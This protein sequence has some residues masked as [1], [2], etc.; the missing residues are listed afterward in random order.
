MVSEVFSDFNDSMISAQFVMQT[1]A[2]GQSLNRVYVMEPSAELLCESQVWGH[3]VNFSQSVLTAGSCP[4]E[5]APQI[6]LVSVAY[7][8]A[9]AAISPCTGWSREIFL[10][11]LTALIFVLS[12]VNVLSFPEVNITHSG[13]IVSVLFLLSCFP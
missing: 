9:L 5:A 1:S 4:Q 11:N 6:S 13:I 7:V 2:D 10:Y 8:E 3:G 12:S